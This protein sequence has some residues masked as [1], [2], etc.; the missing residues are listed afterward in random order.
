METG[1]G[2]NSESLVD[3]IEG[4]LDCRRVGLWRCSW[5]EEEDVAGFE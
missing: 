5:G 4:C 1:R 3:L 2:G